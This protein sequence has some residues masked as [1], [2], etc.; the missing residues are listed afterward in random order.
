MGALFARQRRRRTN[1]AERA[2]PAGLAGSLASLL[3][4]GARLAV[5]ASD[6][7]LA[8]S[9]GPTAARCWLANAR[10]A[11]VPRRTGVALLL[12]LQ[13]ACIAK[14]AG[15]ARERDGAALR[16]VVRLWASYRLHPLHTTAAREAGGA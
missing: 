7:V 4:I 3:L 11:K 2:G 14:G 12:S 1:R 13:P 6:H 5:I 9:D 10:S 15:R 16:T 8:G